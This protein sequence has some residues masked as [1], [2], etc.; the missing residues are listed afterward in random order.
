VDA[1]REWT[2]WYGR[3]PV[4]KDWDPHRARTNGQAWRAERFSRGDWP[5]E[6]TVRLVFGS[7]SDAFEAAAGA[8]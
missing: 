8:R 6:R 7:W 4:K 3:P 5:P 2:D 1:I